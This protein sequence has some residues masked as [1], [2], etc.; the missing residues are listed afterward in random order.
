MRGDFAGEVI[1]AHAPALVLR[2]DNDDCAGHDAILL[3]PWAASA[4]AK[5]GASSNTK[6]G[7]SRVE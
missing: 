3:Y 5:I 4:A 2:A 7:S 6:P 1:Q